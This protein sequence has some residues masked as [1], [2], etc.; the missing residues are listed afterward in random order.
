[1]ALRRGSSANLLLRTARAQRCAALCAVVAFGAFPT[2]CRDRTPREPTGPRREL[3][4]DD[5]RTVR[6]PVH[7]E[8]VVVANTALVDGVVAL[9]EPSRV[10]A[11]CSQAFTWSSLADEP[12]PWRELPSFHEFTAET[13]LALEPD[14]VLA[15]PFSQPETV[16][17][18]NRTGLSVVRLTDPTTLD[19]V[20]ARLAT[21]GELL[22]ARD[23]AAT[24][25]AG[26]RQRIAA[27]EARAASRSRR[28]S[29][30][31]FTHSGS[32]GWSAG[33][34][35][36][37]HAA[38]EL[39]GLDNAIAERGV[40]GPY[41]LGFE[42]LLDVDPEILVVPAAFGEVESSTARTL[43]THPSLEGL[44]AVRDDRIVEVPPAL[45]STTSHEI[46]TTAEAIARAIDAQDER[47]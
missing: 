43:R 36:L 34:D 3:R 17:T 12:G 27:L 5:G 38:L 15:S 32:E 40:A 6:V 42:G 25:T 23:R 20:L 4:L 8:R 47:R 33:S 21:L 9:I 30:A 29:A 16:A 19:G 37:Q 22:D 18:L 26:L 10:A 7:P 1:M 35:T 39:A 46:V 44:R 28:P 24:V 41:R 13:T 11:L 45:F 2:A 14:L 31:V